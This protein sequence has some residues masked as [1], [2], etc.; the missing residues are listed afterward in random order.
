MAAFMPG[1]SPPEDKIPIFLNFAIVV[2]TFL[3]GKLRGAK[4]VASIPYYFTSLCGKN[5]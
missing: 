1:A 4:Q 2:L 3:C 5:Q